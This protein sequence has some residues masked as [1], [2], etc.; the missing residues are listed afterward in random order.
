MKDQRARSIARATLLWLEAEGLSRA[1]ELE[2]ADPVARRALALARQAAPGSRLEGDILLTRGGIA[3]ERADVSTA[4]ESFQ[5]AHRIFGIVR[6]SR[7]QAIALVCLAMLYL[8]AQDYDAALRYLDEAL[9]THPA[10]AGLAYAIYNSRGLIFQERKDFRRA[11]AEFLQA[12]R[13]AREM[14]S[15]SIEAKYLRNIARNALLAG[16]VDVAQR[17][18]AQARVLV[19]QGE[20]DDQS[21]LD[22]VAA[23]AALQQGR[24]GAAG[25]LIDRAFVGIDIAKTDVA[26]RDAHQT[27]VAIYRKHQK[28]ALALA[29][30]QALKRLDDQATRLAAQANTA[31]M[32][33]RFDSANQ[34]AKITRLR[35]AERLRRARAQLER[36]E[37]ERTLWLVGAG[38]TGTV[39]ILLLIS[40]QMIRRSRDQVRAANADLAVT[41]SALSK[42]LAAKT[43]FLATTSHEIR[44]PLNGI[45]GMTQVML[46]D[47]SLAPATRDRLTVVHGAGM[48]MRALVDDILDVAKMETGNLGLEV[49]PFDLRTMLEEASR[50]WAEQ[51]SAKGLTFKIELDQCPGRVE[52]DVARVRQI[53]FNLLSNACKFTSQGS[54]TLSAEAGDTGV[55]IRVADTGIGI[56]P[57]QH[58]AVFESFRQ[59]DASTT[60]QFGGTGLGLSIC[61]NLARA[62]D[63]EVTLASKPGEG[64]TFTVALPLPAA[65]SAP[66][67]A[68]PSEGGAI[69]VID[70]NPIV[71]A[72]MRTLLTPH[73]A[74]VVFAGTAA[75]AAECLAAGGIARV[76]IDDATARAD[77]DPR[78]FVAQVVASADG[79]LVALLWP[80]GE[81]AERTALLE[82]GI[83]LLIPKPITGAALV[84]QLFPTEPAAEQ[85]SSLV[86]RAA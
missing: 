52:G 41:N 79:A 75:E 33:A 51:A 69:L 19:G 14:G 7:K 9:E 83:G 63:G 29:H 15:R 67:C 46:T 58:Q 45:L 34:E 74:K 42:A 20:R 30:L 50:M 66:V 59:A 18:I 48:T 43:E 17:A 8:D 44:T 57:E 11:D 40:I 54:V 76:L 13:F 38:A 72:M 1:S 31:L 64:S 4:L 35:D 27:A 47:R 55:L 73:A 53:V 26:F 62:M 12:L 61:R 68:A 86:P 28:P 71:R 16:K 32:A 60:R 24:L 2:A 25:E 84:Q 80:K 21:Q 70:R 22:A 23:Q 78:G 82:L 65:T 37:A 6:D 81:E 49:A 3:G 77:A 85:Q 56:A 5:A 10:D 36:A 39:I